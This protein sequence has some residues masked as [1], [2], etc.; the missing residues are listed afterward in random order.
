MGSVQS[1]TRL[2][3]ARCAAHA[4]LDEE[5]RIRSASPSGLYPSRCTLKCLTWTPLCARQGHSH[6]GLCSCRSLRAS[7][8]VRAARCPCLVPP[9]S[10]TVVTVQY[11][12]DT[13]HPSHLP[14]LEGNIMA[15]PVLC[16]RQAVPLLWSPAGG[17]TVMCHRFCH[18]STLVA[19]TLHQRGRAVLR[20]A[21]MMDILVTARSR[22]GRQA[23]G[24]ARSVT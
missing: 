12:H 6:E 7:A 9:S 23:N 10:C 14:A 20:V 16:I 18:P 13:R 4:L 21:P 17:P 1:L 2:L 22:S 3:P 19:C 8:R 24:A 11:T 15:C 5:R